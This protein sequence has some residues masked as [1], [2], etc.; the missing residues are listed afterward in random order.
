MKSLWFVNYEITYHHQAYARSFMQCSF[1]KASLTSRTWWMEP[2][3]DGHLFWYSPIILCYWCIHKNDATD[4]PS[5][6]HAPEAAFPAVQIDSLPQKGRQPGLWL[7]NTSVQ[8]NHLGNLKTQPSLPSTRRRSLLRRT[9]ELPVAFLL[10]CQGIQ[11]G[12]SRPHPSFRILKLLWVQFVAITE[13]T[14]L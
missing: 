7:L 11:S 6:G 13:W 5:V 1:N 14:T 9:I 8:D 4:L 12:Q 10:V 2:P 3:A